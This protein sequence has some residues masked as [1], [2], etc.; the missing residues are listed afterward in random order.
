MDM[1][2]S[3]I[4]TAL[5]QNNSVDEKTLRNSTGDKQLKAACDNFE[6]FFMQQ[7]LDVSLK[8]SK[9][10]GEGT[11]SEIIKGMYTENISKASA[12]T[13]GISEIL[14]TFLTEQKK[15]NK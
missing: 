15:G 9:I 2:T 3:K 4:N 14:F 10:A 1:L 6:S 7:M 11:G 12:G 5:L 8:N 13:L